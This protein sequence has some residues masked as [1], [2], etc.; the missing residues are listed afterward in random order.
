[1]PITSEINWA[2]NPVLSIKTGPNVL[3]KRVKILIKLYVCGASRVSSTVDPLSI[4]KFVNFPFYFK[5]N[6]SDENCSLF[7][8]SIILEHLY[9]LSSLYCLSRISESDLVG[10][11]NSFE[12]HIHVLPSNNDYN[13]NINWAYIYA[14]V[15]SKKPPLNPEHFYET[16]SEFNR[17]VCNYIFEKTLVQKLPL[18]FDPKLERMSI[19]YIECLQRFYKEASEIHNQ[20]PL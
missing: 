13:N 10:H 4:I 8:T 3:K 12:H 16:R 5:V 19:E 14:S 20:L 1:M 18:V 17:K 6:E 7:D 2:Y 11:I 15:D 9:K